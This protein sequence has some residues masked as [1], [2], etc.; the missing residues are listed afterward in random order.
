MSSFSALITEDSDENESISDSNNN[1]EKIEKTCDNKNNN[2]DNKINNNQDLLENTEYY[3]PV[4]IE[5]DKSWETTK[6]YKKNKYEKKEYLEKKK[7]YS[8]TEIDSEEL[9]KLGNNKLLNSNWTIWV[10]NNE[11]EDWSLESYDK[12]Y[13]I[14]SIGSYWRFF[15]NFH[16][17]DKINNHFFI[18]REHITPIWEDVNNRNGG[19]CSFKIDYY[20][21]G[22]RNDI[23]SEIMT[24]LSTL[25]IN[26]SFIPSNSRI[27]G[28]SYSIKN[29]SI[30]IKLWIKNFSESEKFLDKLPI[31]L[32]NKINDLL[33][34]CDTNKKGSSKISI[35]YKKIIP[36]YA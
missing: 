22:G 34:S 36:E 25:I 14:S 12:I 26:E 15:N 9:N 2:E 6:K 28:I 20:N 8:E 32:L 29:R 13:D 1:D 23:G 31:N 33:K 18:M 30:M 5:L 35:Q 24:C 17:L 7:I 21:K 3:N 4:N 11:K 16:L 19:I 10:H 27:N